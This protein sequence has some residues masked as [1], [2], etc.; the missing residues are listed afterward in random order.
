MNSEADFE[1][2]LNNLYNHDKTGNS[3]SPDQSSFG[4]DCKRRK[5]K[6]KK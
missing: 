4:G 3:S 5:T 2:F 6:R 1:D